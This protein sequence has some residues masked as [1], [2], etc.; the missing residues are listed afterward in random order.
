MDMEFRAVALAGVVLLGACGFTPSEA[1][2]LDQEPK[3]GSRPAASD[4]AAG[5]SLQDTL[6]SPN[7]LRIDASGVDMRLKADNCEAVVEG[8]LFCSGTQLDIA[9]PDAAT[10]HALNT[11]PMLV[12][13][14]AL[15]FRG[16]LPVDA[17]PEAHSIVISDV[18]A[19]DHEDL[20]LWSGRDGAYGGPSFDVYLFDEPRGAF[21]LNRA[22][23]D[24]T[25]GYTGLFGVDGSRITADSLTGC[26]VRVRET[27]LVDDGRPELVERVTT[28]DSIQGAP[29]TVTERLVEGELRVIIDTK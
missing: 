21:R 4:P 18:N 23:S 10:Q 17:R 19:D 14:D 29:A 20:L 7:G 8:L 25:V 3:P 26:C 27:Y 13:A 15:A 16:P 28:D 22:L 24:L 6:R 5:G 12:R 11:G 9:F 2:A 1:E